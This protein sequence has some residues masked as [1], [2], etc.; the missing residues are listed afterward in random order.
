[1]A[2]FNT[3]ANITNFRA[4][5]IL[6]TGGL[7]FATTGVILHSVAENRP[8]NLDYVPVGQPNGSVQV[9]WASPG[10]APTSRDICAGRMQSS[11]TLLGTG[12]AAEALR[13]EVYPNPASADLQLS[14][15][16]GAAQLRLY[17]AQG[18]LVRAFADGAASLPVRG[19]PVGLYVLRGTVAGQPASRRVAV[20]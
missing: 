4:Q 18:R 15:P 14:R 2:F 9:F 6:P 20:E 19:L 12:R 5:K 17:D 16:S 10:G 7:A 13:F 1:M 8:D 11:G 3:D